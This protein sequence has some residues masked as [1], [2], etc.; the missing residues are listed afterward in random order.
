METTTNQSSPLLGTQTINVI[1]EKKEKTS[2]IQKYFK[3]GG[4]AFALTLTSNLIVGVL[5][6][7]EALFSFPGAYV[8]LVLV[9]SI[10]YYFMWPIIPFKILVNP[11]GYFQLGGTF[12]SYLY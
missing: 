6:D 9:K 12:R 3:I 5:G 4:Y 11:Q 7:S 10:W 8:S 1:L 2:I